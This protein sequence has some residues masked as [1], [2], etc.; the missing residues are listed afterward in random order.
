MNI[1]GISYNDRIKIGK[2][3]FDLQIEIKDN[4]I[5]GEIFYNGKVLK[6][7]KKKRDLSIPETIDV[8]NVHN[9]LRQLLINKIISTSNGTKKL[10]ELQTRI[11]HNSEETRKKILKLLDLEEGNLELFLYKSKQIKITSFSNSFSNRKWADRI[12]KFLNKLEEINKKIPKISNF[13]SLLLILDQN[14]KKFSLLVLNYQNSRVVFVFS[15]TKLS[16]IRKNINK[17]PHLLS[18][19]L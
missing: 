12:E 17:I 15:N 7:I 19:I 3:S 6:S 13:R 10:K 14:S 2:Y 16:F 5:I 8:H 11:F 4:L 9:Y 18:K 1:M